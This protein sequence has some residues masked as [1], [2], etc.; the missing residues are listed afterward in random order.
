MSNVIRSPEHS[1]RATGLT[2]IGFLLFASITVAPAQVRAL[3]YSGPNGPQSWGGLCNIGRSQTPIDIVSSEAVVD[4]SLSVLKVDYSSR[5]RATITNSAVN[6]EL[7]VD[8]EMPFGKL[9]LDDTYNL[10]G[11]HFHAPSEHEINGQSYDLELHLVHQIDS[12]NS[13]DLAVIGLLYNQGHDDSSTDLFLQQ[14]FDA[15][16]SVLVPNTTRYMDTNLDFCPLYPMLA[17]SYARYAGSLTTPPCS[18]NVIW[19]VMLN[20]NLR[21]SPRQFEAYKSVFEAPNSRPLQNLSGRTVTF[22]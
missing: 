5:T 7:E 20:E 13:T 11:F 15:L 6:L 8:G 19:T 4:R 3:E 16:P 18:E 2:F 10:I 17:G 22:F 9:Y 14:V 1:S 12:S 21:V